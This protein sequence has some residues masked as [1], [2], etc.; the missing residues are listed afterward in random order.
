MLPLLLLLA[1]PRAAAGYAVGAERLFWDA[2]EEVPEPRAVAVAEGA[3]P[4]W[5]RG[6]LFRNGP[7]VFGVGRRRARVGFDGMAKPHRWAVADGRLTFQTRFL[8]SDSYNRSVAAGTVAPQLTFGRLDPCISI[9]GKAMALFEP[10]DN[11]FVSVK[12]VGDALLTLSDH[13]GAV[14]IDPETLGTVE[15]TQFTPKPPLRVYTVGSAHPQDDP[16]HPGAIVNHVTSV[17]LPVEVEVYR[18]L[19]DLRKERV[20]PLKT[21][22]VSYMHSFSVVDN[23]AFFF[24]YPAIWD[25]V[26]ISTLHPLNECIKV[27]RPPAPGLGGGLGADLRR[28]GLAGPWNGD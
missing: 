9:F 19:P 10:N 24:F 13:F 26:C 23:L 7:G 27:G 5:L 25:V 6:S 4:A 1:G 11:N 28:Q 22:K 15:S 17:G 18:L 12:R 3:L 16:T 2:P 21:D 14:V 20:G 8:R